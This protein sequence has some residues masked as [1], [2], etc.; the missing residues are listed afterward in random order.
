MTKNFVCKKS[1]TCANYNNKC[2][3]CVAL[4]HYMDP[5]PH[6]KEFVPSPK[7]TLKTKIFVTIFS[8]ELERLVNE[9][10]LDKDIVDIQ[11][12]MADHKCGVSIIYKED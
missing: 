9:F 12:C 7:K 11:F 3:S 8:E 2:D 10:I 6:Y 4:S 1:M 5:Y